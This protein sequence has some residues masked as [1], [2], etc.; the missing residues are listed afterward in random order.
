VD[1]VLLGELEVAQELGVHALRGHVALGD[2]LEDAIAVVLLALIVITSVLR[3]GHFDRE[4]SS[5]FRIGSSFF[6]WKRKGLCHTGITRI[7]HRTLPAVSAATVPQQGIPLHQG[8]ALAT[9]DE[10]RR[11]SERVQQLVEAIANLP[12]LEVTDLNYALK[13]RLNLPD[14]PSFPIGATFANVAASSSSASTV[15]QAPDATPD[16]PQKMTF[17]VKLIKFDEAKKIALIKEIRNIVPGFNLVQAKKFVETAPVNVK[18]D[19]GKTEASDLKAA[20]EAVGGT[21]E[22]V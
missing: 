6:V 17:A 9:P 2:R 7:F 5:S 11:V 21:C 3:F 16:I 20:I 19:L 15:D 13:K 1:V 12:L 8:E 18:E 10:P 4:M 22:I 14:T